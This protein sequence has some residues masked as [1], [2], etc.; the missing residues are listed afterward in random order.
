MKRTNPFDTIERP[1]LSLRSQYFLCAIIGT[2]NRLPDPELPMVLLNF[3][4]KRGTLVRQ[5]L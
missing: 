5:A 4:E 2:G 3:M 1:Q